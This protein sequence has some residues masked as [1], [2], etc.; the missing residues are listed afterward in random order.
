MPAKY[1][2]FSVG[3]DEVTSS[4]LVSS[5]KSLE[6]L[7]FGAFCCFQKINMTSSCVWRRPTAAGGRRMHSS[8]TSQLWGRMSATFYEENNIK[9]TTLHLHRYHLAELWISYAKHCKVSWCKSSCEWYSN[10]W[11]QWHWKSLPLTSQSLYVNAAD[12][13]TA[14]VFRMTFQPTCLDL[15]FAGIAPEIVAFTAGNI[16]SPRATEKVV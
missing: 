8:F 14:D 16:G 10:S 3:K 4:N 5:S 2:L 1:I 15:K 7:G 13:V 9:W 11:P 12:V 6:S